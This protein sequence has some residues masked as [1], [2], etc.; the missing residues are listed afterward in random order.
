MRDARRFTL[1]LLAMVCVSFLCVPSVR[2]A[3][4]YV[5][6]DSPN[7][8]PGSDWGHAFRTVAAGLN[9]AGS[10]DQVWVARG[11]YVERITLKVDVGLYGGFAGSE[12]DLPRMLSSPALGKPQ[13]G[14]SG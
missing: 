3:I 7:D 10:G 12:S 9:A 8:G 13:S 2:S 14:G 4:I 5:E 11:T 1:V 6:W